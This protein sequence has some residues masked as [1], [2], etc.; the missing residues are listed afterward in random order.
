MPA[1]AKYQQIGS[2]RAGVMEQRLA[3][4]RTRIDTGDLMGAATG[5][6]IT[7]PSDG[8]FLTGT[9][10][11]NELLKGAYETE[12]PHRYKPLRPILS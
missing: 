4:L 1:D 8:E 11:S 10:L 3:D 6:N 7:M 12:L 2:F 5:A 9:E